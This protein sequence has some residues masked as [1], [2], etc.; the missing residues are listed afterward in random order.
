MRSASRVHFGA[1][2][3]RA[4]PGV[5]RAR[6]RVLIDRLQRRRQLG[7]HQQRQ[8]PPRDDRQREPQVRFADVA[9]LVHARRGEE[10]LESAD[11]GVGQRVELAGVAGHHTAPEFHVHGCGARRVPLPLQGADVGRRRH[12]V[13][14]HVH[15]RGDAAR[16]GRGRRRFESFPLGPSR[17]VDV[18]VGVDEAGHEEEIAEV[19]DARREVR[20][21][22]REVRGAFRDGVRRQCLFEGR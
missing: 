15:N 22:R 3:T 9:E 10:A 14:R 8:L 17:I 7:V 2:R 13:Q 11:A 20:G 1:R 21:G 6:I 16:G 19:V 4:E 18:D 12:A 5:V